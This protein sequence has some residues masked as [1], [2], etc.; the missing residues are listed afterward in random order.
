[1]KK[2]LILIILLSFN[3]CKKTIQNDPTIG[4]YFKDKFA[5]NFDNTCNN[6][7]K[8]QERDGMYK[9]SK[10][11]C[12]F[13]A[14]VLA[15]KEGERCNSEIQC[16]VEEFKE[17]RLQNYMREY[18]GF[19]EAVIMLAELPT[20][21]VQDYIGGEHTEILYKNNEPFCI[22]RRSAKAVESARRAYSKKLEGL[23]KTNPVKNSYN[24]EPIKNTANQDRE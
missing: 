23:K 24:S 13:I 17:T 11:D 14:D 3:S 22:L 4:T 8:K 2:I 16:E 1:M 20:C 10:G 18:N 7:D 15:L 6:L 21:K 19:A 12:V 5:D 9:T